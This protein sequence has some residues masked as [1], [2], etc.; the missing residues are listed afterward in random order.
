MDKLLAGTQTWEAYSIPL[1]S[2]GLPIPTPFLKRRKVG[3]KV[4]RKRRK[5]KKRG[6]EVRKGRRKE[7][8]EGGWEGRKDSFK[9]KS[10]YKFHS[11]S[12]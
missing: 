7:G 1:S 2:K 10:F 9:T 8:K 4:R 3:R 6:R 12:Y 11:F 5:E